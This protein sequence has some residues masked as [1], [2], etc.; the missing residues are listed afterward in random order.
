MFEML[1]RFLQLKKETPEE[2][3]ERQ[4]REIL[5]AVNRHMEGG[6][7]IRTALR[8]LQL[9]KQEGPVSQQLGEL[10]P[11]YSKTAIGEEKLNIY[12]GIVS[13]LIR[14]L[15]DAPVTDLNTAAID[16]DI[17]ELITYFGNA[18]Q[19]GNEKS[20]SRLIVNISEAIEYSRAPFKET[21]PERKAAELVARTEKTDSIVAIAEFY[22]VSD[23]IEKRIREIDIEIERKRQVL[24]KAR[25][26]RQE[27]KDSNPDADAIIQL[28]KE[29]NQILDMVFLKQLAN[30]SNRVTTAKNVMDKWT[31]LRE[32][33]EMAKD[34]LRHIA[35]LMKLQDL[36]KSPVVTEQ[37]L[38]RLKE[39]FEQSK[40]SV[41]RIAAQER[42]I[43]DM[44]RE[45]EAIFDVMQEDALEEM[46]KSLK[47]YDKYEKEIDKAK[48][49]LE[50][51][52]NTVTENVVSENKDTNT[53]ASPTLIIEE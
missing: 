53:V 50:K 32:D 47:E 51:E 20:A 28:Y 2:A 10:D 41:A 8:Q 46:Q 7:R 30:Y 9:N 43:G 6:E 21:V 12:R 49:L 35:D 26:E 42:I 17:L 19:Q 16:N 33:Q 5:D 38:D 13:N 4:K 36:M 44:E 25:K 39:L 15:E 31:L 24:E 52:K 37:A 3:E 29:K 48:K 45:A 14:E 18:M 34:K 22:N 1:G 23:Q 11:T 27:F 40:N